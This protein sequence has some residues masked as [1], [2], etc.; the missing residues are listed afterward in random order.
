M[1][2]AV[3]QERTS[4]RFARAFATGCGG[5]AT[6]DPVLADGPIA[7]FGSPDRWALLQQAIAEGRTWY[8]GDHGYYRRGK[9]YRVA[10]NA[11][12][13]QPTRDAIL[14]A[15]PDRLRACHVEINP[16][17]ERDGTSIVI[18]PNSPLYMSWFGIDAHRWVVDLV[19]QLGRVAPSRP[20]IVRWKAMASR[21]PLAADLHNAHAVIVFSSNAAV[22]A[23]CHGIPVFVLAPWASTAS[24]GLSDITKIDT[25]YYP[26][27]RV[28]FLWH[29]AERQWTLSE[30]ESGLAWH[31]LHV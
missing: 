22:E 5:P 11:Y 19:D 23:L 8:Y 13:Y 26:E 12:Q 9:Y 7:L 29:L 28:P 6:N 2:Y 18:C 21:R 4:P 27:L 14:H 15:R 25:P 16:Q 31:D 20:I 24:M 17:W 3:P 1:T 10:R 30:I